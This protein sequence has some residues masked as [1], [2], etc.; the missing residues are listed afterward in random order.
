MERQLLRAGPRLSPNTSRSVTAGR[1]RR[2][3]RRADPD[4]QQLRRKVRRAEEGEG[5]ADRRRHARGPDRDL[6]VKLPDPKFSSQTK[7][8]LVSSEVRQPLEALIADKLAE[9]LEENPA[10]ART[11]M[12]KIIDAAAAREAA[13]KGARPDAAQGRARHRQPARQARRLPGARS[14]EIRAVPRRGDSAGGS[15]SRGA[16]RLSG[17]PP[18]A[19]QDPQRRTRALRP[20]A[21][22]EGDRHDDPGARLRHRPR[23]VQD[24]EA[25]LS[26][27]RH[28]DRCRRRRRAY[29]DPAA[30]LLLSP[31]ARADP[32]R[33][34]LHRPAAAL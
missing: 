8:K 28:H 10:H 20:D 29:P 4:A 27:G 14:G 13:K 23:R 24:R 7:D 19:R 32:R 5:R 11:I 9:W 6:S 2:L 34:P 22:V 18:A 16:T 30:D 26:Q 21:V 33:L 1:T 15:A 12:G 17:D 31:D 3:P 25:A